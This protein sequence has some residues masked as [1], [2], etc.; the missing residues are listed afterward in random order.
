MPSL[1]HQSAFV[2]AWANVYVCSY[3]KSPILLFLLPKHF[4]FPNFFNLWQW[5]AHFSILCPY[6]SKTTIWQVFFTEKFDI[7]YYSV[8]T[9]SSDSSKCTPNRLAAGLRPDQLGELTAPPDP[10]AGLRGV[11]PRGE[12][13]KWESRVRRGELEPN[14]DSGFGGIE[15]TEYRRVTDRQTD[16][17]TDTL[18]SLLPALASC[19]AGKK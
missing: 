12:E 17:R 19:R 6:T 8:F 2:R 16:G 13:G 9:R 10:L 5:T 7:N 1:P 4:Y 18:R 15:A 3:K 11:D 14:F